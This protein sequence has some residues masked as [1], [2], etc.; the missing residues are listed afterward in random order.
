[1]KL[2]MIS[3]RKEHLFMYV[4]RFHFPYF[5]GTLMLWTYILPFLSVTE[6]H[7]VFQYEYHRKKN[8]LK[9][10]ALG[11]FLCIQSQINNIYP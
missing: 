4:G 8:E 3:S 7:L 11:L 6:I 9:I 2:I 10:C 1:M 5:L